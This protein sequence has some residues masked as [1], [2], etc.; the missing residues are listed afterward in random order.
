MSD[1]FTSIKENVQIFISKF[2]LFWVK[3]F[4]SNRH[5][6]FSFSRYDSSQVRLQSIHYVCLPAAHTQN[7]NF[8]MFY[9]LN[10][11]QIVKIIKYRFVI[12]FNCK[13]AIKGISILA[14]FCV[15]SIFRAIPTMMR[16]WCPLIRGTLFK[17]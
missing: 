9:N 13:G 15:N 17:L 3:F 11:S 10:T 5:M 8:F 16:S 6:K 7:A 4:F 2:M 14:P 12:F 1:A